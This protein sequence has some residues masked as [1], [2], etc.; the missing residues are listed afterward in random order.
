M[1]VILRI[2]SYSGLLLTIL[3]SFLVY[4]DLV[5]ME[6]HKLIALIGSVMWL[7]TA[8]FWL[9]KNKTTVA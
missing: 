7:S 3:P 6:K 1:K 4:A 8:P 9:N 5:T 2:I